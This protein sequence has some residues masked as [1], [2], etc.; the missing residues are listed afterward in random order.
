M[1]SLKKIILV[2]LLSFLLANTI[3]GQDQEITRI[4]SIQSLYVETYSGNIPLGSGTG[5]VIKSQSQNYLITNWHVTTNKN[6][7]TKIWIDPKMPLS[8]DRIRILHNATILGN[9]TFKE[10]KLI[11]ITGKQTFTEFTI[12]NEM[13]DVVA[14]PLK[15][16][17][18]I[19]LYP[20]DY[21]NTYDSI[22]L[23]PTDRVFVLGFPLGKMSFPAFPIW[24]SGLIASE[25]D[26]DQEGKPIIWI[27]MF[28]YG[29]M[30]G[31]PVYIIKNKID[32]KNGDVLDIYGGSRIFFV[33]VFSHGSPNIGTGALWKSIYLKKLFR[34]LK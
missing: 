4:E 25:P 1:K 26:I 33:G 30:S 29:G 6:P 18:N 24:K 20:V 21:E 28:G 22:I 14:I 17:T 5:F 15:D 16:T 31:S 12:K 34:T 32:Y 11:D 10:E 8:P 2:Q 19:K 27:D 7:K 9:H 3:I 23:T 13:V